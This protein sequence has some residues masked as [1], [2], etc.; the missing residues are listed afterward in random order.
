MGALPPLMGFA[1]ASGGEVI[2]PDAIALASLLYLWQFPHFFAL[3]WVHR[4]VSVKSFDV[5]DTVAGVF[6][7]NLFALCLS[8]PSGLCERLVPNGA[9]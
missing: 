1:A 4:V 9:G 3:A 8:H 2:V 5:D 6:S 7:Y